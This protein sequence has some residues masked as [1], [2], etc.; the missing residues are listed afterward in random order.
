MVV[1]IAI[2]QGILALLSMAYG[3]CRTEGR[4][5]GGLKATV[6]RRI[7]RLR[8]TRNWRETDRGREQAAQD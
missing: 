1:D 6:F 5:S 7:L 2:G 4:S 3:Q 8:R